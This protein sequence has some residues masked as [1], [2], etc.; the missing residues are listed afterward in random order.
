MT[1][2][3][4][5]ETRG[6]IDAAI[7]SAELK[8]LEEELDKLEPRVDATV[9]VL[10]GPHEWTGDEEITVDATAPPH[11]TFLMWD[12]EQAAWRA[13][14]LADGTRWRIIRDH[15]GLWTPREGGA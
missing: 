2:D 7:D 9:N 15:S 3:M 4:T 5:D 8:R 1:A 11:P 12:H 6:P 13:V 10:L 14:M